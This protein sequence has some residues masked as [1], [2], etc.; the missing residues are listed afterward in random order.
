MYIPASF[1][2][3]DLTRLHR[4]IREH[5]FGQL[6]TVRDG[7]PFVSHVPM[8]LE[9]APAPHGSLLGHIAR[10]NPQWQG[11]DGQQVLAIFTGPHAYVSPSFYEAENVVPTWNYVAVH[12]YGALHVLEDAESLTAILQKSVVAYEQDRENPWTLDPSSP[13]FEKMIHAIVGFRIDITRIEGKWK[14]SQNQPPE[15]RAKVRRALA[16]S[17][18]PEDLAIAQLMNE[19]PEELDQDQETPELGS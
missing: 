1:K 6:T 7:A 2:V 8:L 9:D 15:R 17:S 13:Y 19:Q 16:G 3:S 12:V 4:F 14:L 18:N 11:A 10:A 5:S